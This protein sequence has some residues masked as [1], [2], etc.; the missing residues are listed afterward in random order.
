MSTDLK[1]EEVNSSKRMKRIASIDF[2]RGL[3][4]WMMVFLHVFNHKYDYSWVFDAG[5]ENI[6]QITNPFFAIFILFSGFFGN[7]VGI[8]ILVSGVVNTVSFVKR[9][10]RGDATS[11]VFLKQ[12]MTGFGILIAGFIAESFGYYG[13]FGSLIK[14]GKPFTASTWADSAIVSKIWTQI[15]RMEALQIIG[16]LM[17]IIAIVLFF[18]N[19][20]GG[21]KKVKRNLFIV[22]GLIV[23][24]AVTT[25]FLWYASEQINWLI[26]AS[27]SE[28]VYHLTWPSMDMQVENASFGT[29]L[30]MVL[31]GDYYPL[32]PYL[33]TSLVGVGFGIVLAMEKPPKR[34]PLWG[35]LI[36]IIL[37]VIGGITA[38]FMHFDINF[39][40]P[41]FPF[42]FMLL[43][44]QVGLMT[45]LLWLVE[46][47]GKSQKFGNNIIVK[48]FRIWGVLSLSIFVLQIY[49]LVPYA[50]FNPAFKTVNLLS[51]Q[52]G[53]GGEYWVLLL[54]FV[55]VLFFDLIVWIWAR[56]NFVL[57]FEWMIQRLSSLSTKEKPDKLNFKKI[58]NE[59]EWIDYRKLSGREKGLIVIGLRKI[60]KKE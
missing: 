43:A 45:L 46:F 58:L 14:T 40:R 50:I 4:I 7:W 59:V 2:L 57:S 49:H 54:A 10:S 25:P 33:I 24:I 41:T 18:L 22:L 15:F 60:F 42:F 17:I 30:M 13:Y 53:Q 37:G 38:T 55:T 9:V 23:V 20:N 1:T 12:I 19:R 8:F 27:A 47:R 5:I 51:G 56:F 21:Y 32:F 11:R 36:T 52:F 35:L 34:L 48:Y 31:T 3:A 28:N 39:E 6:F 26:P 44:S 16:Y 29:Y